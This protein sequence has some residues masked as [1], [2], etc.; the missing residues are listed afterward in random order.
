MISKLL[1]SLKMPTLPLS[2]DIFENSETWL[3]PVI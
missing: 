3:A 1:A 2:L